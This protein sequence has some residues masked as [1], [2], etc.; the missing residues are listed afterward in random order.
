M[1]VRAIRS[2]PASRVWAGVLYAGV[3]KDR[4]RCSDMSITACRNSDT[5]GGVS[6]TLEVGVER[7]AKEG[8][9]IHVYFLFYRWTTFLS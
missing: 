2:T 5:G 6:R 9:Q 1:L 3:M 4:H 8:G 7:T